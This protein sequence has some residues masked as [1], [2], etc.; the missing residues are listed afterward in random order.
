MEICWSSIHARVLT[1]I[2]HFT[3][4]RNTIIKNLIQPKAWQRLS[5]KKPLC[6]YLF[7]KESGRGGFLVVP[8][9]CHQAVAA[10]IMVWFFVFFS[11]QFLSFTQCNTRMHTHTDT[12]KATPQQHKLQLPASKKPAR[13]HHALCLRL[14]GHLQHV[15]WQADKKLYHS[16]TLAIR[17][18]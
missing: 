5:S 1:T 7:Q 9:P 8:W 3:G 4:K 17:G 18:I 11:F 15:G 6:Y 10:F 13:H 12:H 16:M 2:S 14:N